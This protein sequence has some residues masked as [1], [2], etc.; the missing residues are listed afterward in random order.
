MELRLASSR[1]S[2]TL[3]MRVSS[4][5]IFYYLVLMNK[6]DILVDLQYQLNIY[7]DRLMRA[8]FLYRQGQDNMH[9]IC[10]YEQKINDLEAEIFVEVIKIECLGPRQPWIFV[11]DDVKRVIRFCRQENVVSLKLRWSWRALRF[12]WRLEYFPSYT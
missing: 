2:R 4:I 1:R 9:D 7:H 11:T 6:M 3:W 10:F 8:K 5:K 12:V